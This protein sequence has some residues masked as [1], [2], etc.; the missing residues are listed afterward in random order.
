MYIKG[1]SK[2]FSFNDEGRRENYSFD[3]VELSPESGMVK[4]GTWTDRH[5]LRITDNRDV[6]FI[7]TMPPRGGYKPNVSYN[8]RWAN[9]SNA[10]IKRGI[11]K[12]CPI[13]ANF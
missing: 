4:I 2:Y 12:M 7:K 8:P 10:Y 9:V 11:Q 13:F 6:P 5:R 3:V 1:N